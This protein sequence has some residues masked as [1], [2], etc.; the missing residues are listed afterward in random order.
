MTND[1]AHVPDL[2]W[3]ALLRLP[4]DDVAVVYL[5]MNH[6]IGLAQAHSGHP[7]GKDKRTALEA[8]RAAKSKG[9]AVFALSNC[10]YMEMHKIKDPAQRR[11]L[12]NVM[13]ELTEFSTLVSRVLVMELELNAAL[14]PF[15]SLPSPLPEI[16]LLGRGAFHAYGLQDGF[17]I[18][19]PNGDATAIVRARMGAKA[20]DTFMKAADLRLQQSVLRGPAD[21]EVEE[22]RGY[23]WQ[24]ESP[25]RIAENRA[26]H[27]RHFSQLL[28]DNPERRRDR[29]RDLISARELIIEFQNILLRVLPERGLQALS[30][31]IKNRDE[32]RA[33]VRSMP[34]TEVAIELKTAWHRNRD[35]QWTANDIFDIDA[36]A[37][38]VPYCDIVVTE[39]ACHHMLTAARFGDR[40]GTALLRSVADL[41]ATLE[42]WRPYR[43]VAAA[44]SPDQ[45]G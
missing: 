39:K 4:P 35:K 15:V 12:A 22:L 2:V 42:N 25:L 13:E 7:N 28:N 16:A 33:F 23:G 29:L 18:K 38:A 20:F 43:P 26:A 30:E 5:D 45:K 24:P 31:A 8:C 27:E 34:T 14:D 19:G 41:P 17:T 10:I 37:L 6:W 44:L 32:A 3:P 1:R 11:N 36:L 40:M 9:T 21:D